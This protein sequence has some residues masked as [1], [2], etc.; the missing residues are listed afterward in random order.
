MSVG[1]C[2]DSGYVI[3]R[4]QGGLPVVKKHCSSLAGVLGWEKCVCI[5]KTGMFF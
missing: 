5:V 2:N 1:T 4:R 3:Q